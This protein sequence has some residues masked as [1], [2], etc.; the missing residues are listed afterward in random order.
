MS[1]CPEEPL[2]QAENVQQHHE[3]G[4]KRPPRKLDMF[5]LLLILLVQMAEPITATV[6]FP[7]VN[8]FVRET[9]ITGGD[10][11]KTGYYA[12]L[13]ESMFFVTEALTVYHWGRASDVYGRKPILLVGLAM[14]VVSTLGFGLSQVLWTMIVFRSIQGVCNGNIG[15]TKSVMAEI[16]DASNIAYV[17]STMSIMWATGSTMG[18]V[19]GGLLSRPAERWPRLFSQ[20]F[21][22]TYPYFLPCAAAA[23]IVFI[24]VIITAIGL[25]ETN[26][27]IIKTKE[28]GL[29]DQ[30]PSCI[31]AESTRNDYGTMS[32][33]P[34]PEPVD[35]SSKGYLNKRIMIPMINIGFL[36]FLQQS[37]SVLNPLIFSTSIEYGGLGMDPYEIG[38][39]LGFWG[40]A[41]GLMQLFVSHR[42]ISWL[43]PKRA[44]M[45]AFGNHIILLLALTAM[46]LLVRTR[47]VDGLVKTILVVELFFMTLTSMGYASIHVFIIDSASESSLGSINGFAQM[48]ASIMRA[49]APSISSSLYS[50]SLEQGYLNGTMA[51]WILIGITLTGIYISTTLPNKLYRLKH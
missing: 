10:E 39:I 35:S 23:F 46:S 30:E 42:I 18:P 27:A 51:F 4:P 36:A 47:G 3:D 43:G 19:I 21:W 31:D 7:F 38:T 34:A 1:T 29:R 49:L 13:I 50:T 37:I 8:Q 41:N 20:A 32:P 2:L 9:G 14:L 17:F 6:I 48:V 44:Y 15:V 26:P 24:T 33:Q 25:K 16:S 12:G 28:R 45:L 11:R 5:Q 40:V 22:E